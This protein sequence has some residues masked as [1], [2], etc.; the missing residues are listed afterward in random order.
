VPHPYPNY[1]ILNDGADTVEALEIPSGQ[2]TGIKLVRNFQITEDTIVELVLDFDACRSVVETGDHKFLLKPTIKVSGAEI[3]TT[4]QGTVTDA[5]TDL[6]LTGALVSAQV[7]EGL[8]ASVVRA[9]LTSDDSGYEGQYRLTLSPGQNYGVVVFS[10]KKTGDSGSEQMY[11]PACS[12]LA[13]AASTLDFAL[14]KTDFGTISGDVHVA[15]AIDPNDP[16]VV[17]I[18]FYRML[19]CG[20][21]EL[22]SLPMSPDPDSQAM[23][24]AV[25]LPLGT[26]DVVASGEGL[27]PAT[28]SSVEISSPGDSVH[29][30]L[31]L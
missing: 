22:V 18:G 25:D 30:N 21:M 31:N 9:T 7:S 10:D 13:P 2:Q 20:Y 15:G 23:D 17:Y 6:P 1:V 5:A 26:Y 14:E 3:K 29:V 11:A 19:D 27:V 28:A 12:D 24:L 4:V 16:P 8:S